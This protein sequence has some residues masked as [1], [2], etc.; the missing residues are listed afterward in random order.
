MF[1]SQFALTVKPEK[2]A[3]FLSAIAG[4]IDRTLRLPGCLSCRLSVDCSDADAYF[5]TS[6]WKDQAA[7]VGFTS[8]RVLGVLCGMRSLLHVEPRV[9]LDEVSKRTEGPLPR[10]PRDETRGPAGQP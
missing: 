10:V 5:L 7:F 4:I 9:V 3:E 8:S 1:I 2:R 6:E